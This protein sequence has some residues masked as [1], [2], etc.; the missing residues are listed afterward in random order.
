MSPDPAP[1]TK[2]LADRMLGTL[3]RYL[4]FMGYDT[5][6]ANGMV[7]GNRK[8]DTVLLDLALQENRILLTGD[9][10][11]ARRGKERAVYIRS[12]D[13][14]VQIQA[15]V[16]RGLVE[17]RLDLSRCSICN[18]VLRTATQEEIE[19][20]QYAPQD[21]EGLVFTW[22]NHCRKLYWNGSHGERIADLLERLLKGSN[23]SGTKNRNEGKKPDR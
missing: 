7:P 1:V 18:T 3:T 22:C 13:I 23:E 11:L 8:E 6:S 5:T 17:P 10:E 12:G 16:D 14:A 19:R 20:S 15:L 2:F 21:Q 4:R 9:A